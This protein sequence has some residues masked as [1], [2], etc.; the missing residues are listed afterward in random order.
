MKIIAI[1]TSSYTVF[2]SIHI[3]GEAF[4]IT[5]SSPAVVPAVVLEILKENYTAVSFC[6]YSSQSGIAVQ[7]NSI[8]GVN[9][10]IVAAIAPILPAAEILSHGSL[11]AALGD[12][13]LGFLSRTDTVH[14]TA[15][16][17]AVEAYCQSSV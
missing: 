12:S 5:I 3:P 10:I 4:I 7:N 14:C 15:S 6:P 9:G 17:V 8:S 1:K 2:I 16:A 13:V 11:K